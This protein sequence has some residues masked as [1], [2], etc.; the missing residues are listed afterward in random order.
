MQFDFLFWLRKKLP[1]ITYNKVRGH[2]ILIFGQ[3][4]NKKKI[5][6]CFTKLTAKH[7][8]N[9]RCSHLVVKTNKPIQSQVRAL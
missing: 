1:I 7:N 9:T 3:G 2:S 4:T 6:M 5:E 8:P